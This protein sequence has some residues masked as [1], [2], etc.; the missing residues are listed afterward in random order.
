MTN[1]TPSRAEGK[2]LWARPI[3]LARSII[4]L[5]A[6]LGGLLLSAVVL[7]TAFSATM[8]L[9]F[10]APVPGDFELV[11][12]GVAVA[13]SAFLPYCQLTYAN[14]T[15][16]IFTAWAGPR[17]IA[18]LS[19]LASVVAFAFAVILL[20]RMV[21]G[22]LSYMEYQEYTAIIGIP[23]WVAFPPFLLSLV[24]LAVAALIT[25]GES[26]RDIR[27]PGMGAAQPAAR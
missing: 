13:V 25:L 27:S 4:R 18:A 10:H 19:L 22:M 17:L 23:L 16:D 2:P 7:L 12:M 14:V 21:L 6:L 26:I 20:W 15:V 3:G 1:N 24:L 11:E 8:N 9:L 5:W